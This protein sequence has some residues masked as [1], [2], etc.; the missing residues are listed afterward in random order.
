MPFPLKERERDSLT[1]A[2]GEVP[3]GLEGEEG[4]REGDGG[5]DADGDED[6][7]GLVEGGQAAQHQPLAGGEHAEEDVVG[8]GLAADA[9]AAD[10]RDH[11][12]LGGWPRRDF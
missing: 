3:L 4:E 9:L 7:V 12:H 10:H 2:G 6:G 5:A 1:P 8:G 11:A